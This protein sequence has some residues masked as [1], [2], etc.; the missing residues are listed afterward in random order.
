MKNVDIALC[1]DGQTPDAELRIDSLVFTGRPR[2]VQKAFDRL[3]Q[4]RQDCQDA[5]DRLRRVLRAVD[6]VE[7]ESW[8]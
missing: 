1:W 8:R 7:R 3:N 6:E 5:E 4:L 2:D